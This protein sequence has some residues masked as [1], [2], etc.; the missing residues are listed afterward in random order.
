MRNTTFNRFILG[1]FALASAFC[2]AGLTAC[3][4]S[5][6]PAAPPPNPTATISASSSMSAGAS[7]TVTAT[8]ANA[9]TAIICNFTAT[10]GTFGTAT[11]IGSTCS[12]SFT[13]ASSGSTSA[14]LNFTG[15]GATATPV[16]IIINPVV[17]ALNWVPSSLS[18]IAPGANTESVALL[19]VN[20]SVLNGTGNC[21][22]S[23]GNVSISVATNSTDSSTVS[24]AFLASW[25]ADSSHASF[26]TIWAGNS[27]S[28]DK[29]YTYTVTATCPGVSPQTIQLTVTDPAPVLSSVTP[30][31]VKTGVAQDY[32][33][34]GSGYKMRNEPNSL[35]Q[36]AGTVALSASTCPSPSSINSTSG[37]S[38]NFVL[39]TQVTLHTSNTGNVGTYSMWTYNGPTNIGIGGGF[40][41]LANAYQVTLTG[42]AV[43]GGGAL[44]VVNQGANTI[45]L[46]S[47]GTTTALTLPNSGAREPVTIGNSVYVPNGNVISIVDT[48]SNQMSSITLAVTPVWDATDGTSFYFTAVVP[49]GDGSTVGIYRLNSDGSLTLLATTSGV[50]D[51][52]ATSSGVLLWVTSAGLNTLDT[53]TGAQHSVS[54][55]QPADSIAV[56]SD[57]T[58]IVYRLGYPT[59]TVV[60]LATYTEAGTTTFA[61]GILGFND[62]AFS[63]T[64]GSIVKVALIAGTGTLSQTSLGTSNEGD[65]LRGFVLVSGTTP[66]AVTV[67]TVHLSGDGSLAP[68]ARTASVSAQ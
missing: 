43:T 45:S 26:G 18:G 62:D 9:N 22:A 17:T 6:S 52:K 15:G 33:L 40:S 39:S 2:A 7:Q 25:I 38:T 20:S 60:N 1:V 32:T 8:V 64:D 67:Q 12:A 44:A 13:A 31:I 28:T 55:S 57:G 35:T 37:A 68:Q 51:L 50:T 54:L 16:T 34:N 61:K 23:T 5:P 10:G 58:V 46:T 29:I 48:S 63:L 4:G 11:L 14:T 21:A 24:G 66:N 30:A 53:A 65:L 36:E 56:L 47:N 59:A 3:G 42:M 41:C 27:A 49:A 19:V